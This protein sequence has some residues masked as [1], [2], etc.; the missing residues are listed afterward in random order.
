[1]IDL[2][3]W[4]DLNTNNPSEAKICI[5]GVPFDGA[6]SCGKGTAEAPEKLRVLS[7]YLPPTT[8]TGIILDN[9][10][11]YD[12][13]DIAIDLNWER[14]YKEVEDQAYNLIAEKKF[15]FFIGGDHSVTIPLQKA[16]GRYFKENGNQ[17]IGIIHFDSHADICDIY[18]S[19]KWSH[20]CTERRAVED[21]IEPKDLAYVGLRGFEIDELEYFQEHPDILI[22]KARDV[23]MD[24]YMACYKRLEERFKDY[25]AVYFTLDIDVV[26]PAFAPGTGTP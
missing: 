5:M 8:E 22:M 13:G 9:L 18:D 25:D 20:A 11:V 6:V 14:Y 2:N 23:Y 16:F 15:T 1:M 3:P 7:R 26:D 17:K 10:K 24:G 21:V 4:G 19:H 12:M